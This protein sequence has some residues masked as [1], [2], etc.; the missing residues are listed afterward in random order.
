MLMMKEKFIKYCEFAALIEKNGIIL[1]YLPSITA[2]TY[3]VSGETHLIRLAELT[4]DAFS[5]SNNEFHINCSGTIHK[6]KFFTQI[7][8]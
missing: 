1:E 8:I 3:R 2:L 6:I 4:D 7:I 5:V